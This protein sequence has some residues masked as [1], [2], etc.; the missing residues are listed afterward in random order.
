MGRIYLPRTTLS[1]AGY[2]EAMF[3]R[4]ECNDAFRRVMSVEV[5]RAERYLH[6]GTPLVELMPVE[7]RLQVALFIAGGL[8]I[9]A[10]IRE[11]DYDVWRQRPTV[12][13]LDK[14][15]LL[16]GAWWQTR[17]MRKKGVRA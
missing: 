12:S 17:R 14:F 9:L 10:A 2:S 6:A 11:L 16:A 1:D 5:D 13:K 3:D 8:R 7:L 15:K 4:A